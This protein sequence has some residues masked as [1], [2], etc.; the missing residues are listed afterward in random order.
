VVQASR[1]E[2]C[3][4]GNTTPGDG[5]SG[6]CTVEPGY[7]CTNAGQLCTRIWVCGNGRVDPG[8]ACDDSNTVPADGCSADCTLVEPGFTCPRA[9]DGTGGPCQIAPTNVC[10]DAVLGPRE[11]CDDGNTTSND[12]C[13]S[14]CAVEAGWNCPAAGQACARIAFCG[15]GLVSLDLGEQCDDGNTQPG[16]GCSALCRLEPNFACP[17][18]G[19]PCVSTVVCGD[20]RV[21]G[22]EQCDDRNAVGGDGC[23]AAPDC[24]VE[25]GWLCP[26]AGARCVARRCGDTIIAGAE[27]CDDG[28]ATAGDGCSATCKFETGYACDITV[29]PSVCQITSCGDSNPQGAEQCDDGNTRPFDGCYKCLRDPQCTNGVCQSV[30]GDGQ[31]FGGEACDDG[32][33]ARN[34][35]CSPQCTV[36][37]GFAC[38]DILDTP[39]A[40]I[41][42]PVLL[43]DFVG[44]GRTRNGHAAHIDFNQL[45]GSG[46][47]GIVEN[48]LGPNGR[49]VYACPG[50][51]HGANSNC[52]VDN[53]PGHLYIGGAGQR[54]NM[55]NSANFVQWYTDVPG[56]SPGT[57]SGVNITL[58]D[59]VV[60][61]RRTT[62][63]SAGAYRYDSAELHDNGA[64]TSIDFFDP[65]HNKGWVLANF[66][67]S[68]CTPSRNVSFTSE[69]HFW[70]E[71]QGG[72]RFDFSGDDDTWVFVNGTLAVD[73]GGLHV[74]LDG[75]FT[76]D[77][78][79][80]GAGP[81]TADGTAVWGS[82]NMP[83][84]PAG[85][86]YVNLGLTQGGIYEVVMF[87]AERNECGSNFTV[88]LRN[89]NKPKSRCQ[90]TCGD[91][92]L[93][94]DE[95]CDDGRNDGTYGSCLPGCQG[96][97]GYCG[98]ATVQG[99]A[100]TCDD[101]VNLAVY[102]GTTAQCGPNCR[103]A[104][105]CGDGVS[106]NLEQCDDGPN[107]A[108][109]YGRC[110]TTCRLGDRCGDGVQNGP[111]Q[112]DHGVSNGS[113][114]DNCASDCTLKCGNA[115]LD[116]GE[117]CDDGAAQNTGA[118]GTCRPDCA[119][120]P[121]CGDGFRNGTEQCDDGRNDGSYGTCR[122]GCTLADYCGDGRVTTP[123]EACDLGTQNSASAY[124]MNQ[125]T[126]ACRPAPYCG[127]R[128][129]DGAA[130]EVCDDGVNSGQPGSC[131]P[132][133]R[134]FVPLTSCGDATVQPPE[135]CDDG[136]SNG[137]AGSG[138][139]THCRSK[140]GNGIRD[141]GEQCDD[142][143][144]N[145][146]YG[147]CKSDCS[148][149]GYCGDG[150]QNGPE[151]CDRG[152]SN[153]P[154]STAYGTGV[155]T[156]V[157]TYAPFCGDGRVQ[158][159]FGEE[160]DG[161][162]DC[163]ASCRRIIIN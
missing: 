52:L 161:A 156:T 60:L 27:Q 44:Q 147:T 124:G 151:Q 53:N 77:A 61:T 125:C 105:Y 74:R 23:S 107:N 40:S 158:S 81:D 64:G 93:A 34:D 110:S 143:V 41:N 5:C 1:S 54:P 75:Y 114:G 4:D 146:S 135:Q 11:R 36:E 89:F 94:S 112:C 134:G 7:S 51:S 145:G 138:C 149:S 66:E 95:V 24:Q 118:Y 29:V 25:A 159:S 2:G 80:D 47:R 127:D 136:A 55:S 160:C 88:T 101:G 45:G 150:I 144:N 13:S 38:S 37:P 123:P 141:V 99:P 43:R 116:P 33:T 132:N 106:S 140:C 109:V 3:D 111:E 96:R 72:E 130:G 115:A 12:G 90:S 163:E 128:E 46:V 67:S 76:L 79:T 129:V 21:N 71:Y 57:V 35:G 9:S 65:L 102:G 82:P 152:S 121:R 8:E 120:G 31:R 155:C 22:T 32:N 15:D 50:S 69:T 133:C 122:A 98:D 30:C 58:A 148:F 68:T 119:L 84:V 162:S 113:S 126:T 16:E 39:P 154:M 18:P 100:E 6:V 48:S 131:T 73:L 117:Q 59:E 103:P 104:P 78:D 83:G 91:G 19:Q 153:V 63:P 85:G 20:G 86:V 139:D 42:L 56:T 137:T 62:G 70:F 26:V 10:G 28:N 97:A 142:G 49:P 14:T 92:I 87:Q 17:T 157:C 108:D